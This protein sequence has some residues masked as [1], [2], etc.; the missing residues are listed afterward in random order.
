MAL[1]PVLAGALKVTLACAL[2]AVATT[3]VGAPGTVAGVTLFEAAD[4]ALDPIALVATTR[5]VYAVPFVRPVTMCVVAV[6]PALLSTP[7]AGVEVTVYPVI[8]LPPLLTGGVKLTLACAFPPVAVTEVGAPGTVA[9][10]TL[11]DAADGALEPA[12]L[13]ATTVKA[14]EVPFTRLVITWV[15]DV[16]PA[17]LST[18]PAGFEVTV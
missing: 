2:P 9:G 10:V 13:V 4:C 18:P 8:A 12:A 17:L 11:F 14:Y 1:P 3:F 5:K 6:V 15:V 7:P 16:L